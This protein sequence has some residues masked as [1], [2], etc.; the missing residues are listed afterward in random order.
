M[1]ML[2]DPD[3]ALDATQEIL[4]I[5]VTKLSTFKGQSSF[6]TWLYRVATNF[7]LNSK[8]R[9]LGKRT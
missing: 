9:Q 6:T 8:N 3:K 7:L 4:I 2:V 1:R 5:L